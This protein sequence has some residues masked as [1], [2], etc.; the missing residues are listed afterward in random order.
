MKQA[1]SQAR[2]TLSSQSIGRLNVSVAERWL[3]AERGG[4]CVLIV[5]F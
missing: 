3:S 2:G 4:V 1:V 5:A